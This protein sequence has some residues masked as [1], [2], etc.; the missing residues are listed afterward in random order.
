MYV[1]ANFKLDISGEGMMIQMTAEDRNPNVSCQVSFQIP[2]PINHNVHRSAVICLI[3]V[4]TKRRHVSLEYTSLAKV[5]AEK[6]S[7]V[8]VGLQTRNVRKKDDC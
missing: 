6:S 1:P 4:T 3:V 8:P 2:N 7:H 5:S